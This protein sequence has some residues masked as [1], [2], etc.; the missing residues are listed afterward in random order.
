MSWPAIRPRSAGSPSRIGG[1]RRRSTAGFEWP[2]ARSSSWLNADDVL[3]PG[4]VRAVVGAFQAVPDAM[5]VYGDGRL[6]DEAGRTLAPFRFTEPFNWRRL[7]EVHDYILQPT[8]FVRREALE[9]VGYLDEGLTW[10]MDWDLWI[11]IGRRFAVHYLPIPLAEVRIHRDT[12]TSRAGLSK[13]VEMHRIVRPHSR[14]RL[15]PVLFIHGAGT[16]YRMA[17]RALGQP[18]AQALLSRDAHSGTL[19]AWAHRWMDRVIETGQ[20][21][22]ERTPDPGLRRLQPA[23][24]ATASG[25]GAS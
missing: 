13:L 20:L 21:P 11:R 1:R 4:A 3:L 5:M 8:A 24:R 19:A 16:L 9:A 10:A 12:K 25:P 15:P 17:C 7:V 6:I 18:P 23:S 2:R 14:R 22:W